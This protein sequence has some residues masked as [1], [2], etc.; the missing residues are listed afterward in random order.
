MKVLQVIPYMNSRYGGP[1]Y[2]AKSLLKFFLKSGVDCTVLSLADKNSEQNENI[3]YFK[4]TTN[5]WFFSLDFLKNSIKHIKKSDVVLI[6]GVYSF[7]TLW[8]VLMAFILRKKIFLRPAG[9]FDRNSIYSSNFVKNS[10]RYIYLKTVGFCIVVMTDRIVF[11]S[12]KEKENSLYGDSKK[13]ILISNGV[14][15]GHIDAIKC[16]KK[17]FVDNKISLF[18]LGRINNIKGIELLI[19]AINSLPIN[20]K[21]Q[22]ELVIAGD[23]NYK[24][25]E[26]IKSISDLD[27]VKFIGHIEDDTKYCY[28]KQC[29]I[30]VQPSLTEGL[31]LS[32]LEAMACKVNMI[33]TNR[34]GLFEE[35]IDNKAA[36]VINYD[37]EELLHAI[38][39]LINEPCDFDKNGYE[40]IKEKYNWNKIIKEYLKCIY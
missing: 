6:H 33:T 38:Q 36:F 35:L 17:Y 40:M 28:L 13:S 16:E 4:K 14:D 32:M 15:L 26:Y 19:E 21:N 9:M 18:F 3:V 27:I 30:Y 11:N 23:G 25:I 22:I 34:V 20:I 12:K 7:L 2:V 8:S 24:Y 10:F 1:V 31:S 5:I 37:K 39:K 29:D